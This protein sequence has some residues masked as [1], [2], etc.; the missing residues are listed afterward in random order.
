[1]SDIAA[2][3]DTPG[4]PAIVVHG[5]AWVKPGV[6]TA[7][8]LEG[9]E[10]AT[11]AGY[12]LLTAGGTSLEAV[13]AAVR[14]LEDDPNFNAGRGSCLTS[15]GTVEM[16][17][18]LMRGSD[19]AAGAVA[20]VT[21]VRN[22][23][24]L[25]REVLDDGHH[26]LLVGEGALRFAKARAVE[27]VAPE[28]HVTPEQQHRFEELRDAAAR[29]D[30][31]RRKLGTVGAVAVDLRGHVAAATSTGGTAFKRPG[32]V[33]DSPLIGAGT[34]ADDLLAAAS[35][36]GHGESILKLVGAKAVCDAIGAGK[37]PVRAA[38]ALVASLRARL[39]GDAGVIV[40]A[41]DGRAGWAM[42][43]VQMSRGFM[44]AGMP[45]P[46]VAV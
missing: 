20:G 18:S 11:A 41:P 15:D 24:C 42:N 31:D 19:L 12:A 16:D 39:D 5:G 8:I 27:L 7:P 9:L 29:G 28:W 35:C 1:M 30:G 33:G 22:P 34:Y 26:V 23:I 36:T 4:W 37:S 17:A 44:R 25:A 10:R 6:V 14:V 45:R 40:V 46:V 21:G 38:E 2:L 43:T 3:L 32:R 13:E